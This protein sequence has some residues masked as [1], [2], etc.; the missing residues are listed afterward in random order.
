MTGN[1]LRS[2]IFREKP[3]Q[4]SLLWPKINHKK[5]LLYVT[6]GRTGSV[7]INRVVGLIIPQ[8]TEK[9][10]VLHQIGLDLSLKP[11]RKRDY[12]AVRFIDND[13]IGWVLNRA[14]LIV[15]RAGA[16]TVSELAALKKPAILIPIPWSAGDEQ[17]KNA[18]FL[19]KL[20]LAEIIEQEQLNEKI[21]LR[22]IF[23]VV[24]RRGNY[25]LK[26]TI[27]YQ[28]APKKL[29]QLSKSVI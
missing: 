14:A 21:L 1:P 26:S 20:G 12:L 16:N 27:D 22:S 8:L 3:L 11:A 7:M 25:K 9:F 29:W 10:F 28:S 17:R 18:Q 23:K 19:K 4:S 15:S 5:P 2:E 13:D 6:G 24:S